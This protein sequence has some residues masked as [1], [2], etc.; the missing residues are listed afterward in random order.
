MNIIVALFVGIGIIVLVLAIVLA[1]QFVRLSRE[2]QQVSDD[3]GLMLAA[4]QRSTKTLQL[5]VPMILAARHKVG[6]I[7]KMVRS[8]MK[9][10]PK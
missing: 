7:S 5:A 2:L 4:V 8:R 3:T 1:V 6:D 10:E 9:K